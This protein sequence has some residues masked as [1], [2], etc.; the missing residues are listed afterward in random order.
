MAQNRIAILLAARSR[1]FFIIVDA[2]FIFITNKIYEKQAQFKTKNKP[3]QDAKS[4]GRLFKLNYSV[5]NIHTASSSAELYAFILC[6]VTKVNP[7]TL[8]CTACI[9][10]NGITV[11]PASVNSLNIYT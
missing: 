11:R 2:L 5:K 10:S 3:T 4:P 6:S 9:S 8:D 7:F 1:V